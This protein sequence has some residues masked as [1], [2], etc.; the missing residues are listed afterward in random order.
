M[1]V[2]ASAWSGARKASQPAQEQSEV[3]IGGSEHGIDAI[4]VSAFQPFR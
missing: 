4:A 2:V 1:L 3:V